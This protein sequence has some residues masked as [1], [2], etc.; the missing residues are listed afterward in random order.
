MRFRTLR[1]L[2]YFVDAPLISQRVINETAH[3]LSELE[4]RN[5]VP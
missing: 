5:P 2:G 1:A 3:V 4:Q